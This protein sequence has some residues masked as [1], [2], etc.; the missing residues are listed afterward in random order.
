MIVSSAPTSRCS[1]QVALITGATRRI[2][3]C[4]ARTLHAAGMNVALHYRSD[5][6]GA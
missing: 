4:I 5:A 1:A 3:A 2:G 6:A